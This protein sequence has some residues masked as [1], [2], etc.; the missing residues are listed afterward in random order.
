MTE[1]LQL[2][3]ARAL[4]RAI[5]ESGHLSDC[6]AKYQPTADCV[7]WVVKAQHALRLPLSDP[8]RLESLLGWLRVALSKGVHVEE[9]GMLNSSVLADDFKACK[10]WYGEA[11]RIVGAQ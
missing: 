3:A 2:V 5:T 7:C 1:N 11:R 4:E 10:C 9:C 8:D 6:G